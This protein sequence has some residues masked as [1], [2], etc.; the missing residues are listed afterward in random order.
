MDFEDLKV[1]IPQ[2]LSDEMIEYAEN[3]A[4][5]HSRYLFVTRRGKR[6]HCYCTHCNGMFE[7]QGLNVGKQ[8][9]CEK[10]NSLC[11]VKSAA[12][13]RNK[14]VDEVYFVYYAKSVIDPKA[15]VATGIY[16]VRD[17]RFSYRNVKTHFEL[18]AMYLFIPREGS[19]MWRRI[20]YQ[21]MAEGFVYVGEWTPC[22][23]TYS[24]GVLMKKAREF[25]SHESIKQAVQD[26][27]FAWSGWDQYDYR[28]DS[29]MV[30]FFGLYARYPCVEYLVK[31][32]FDN[33]VGGKL[34]GE[35]NYKTINW[36]GKTLFDV[37]R[38]TKKELNEIKRKNITLD[39]ELL[40]ILQMS[41]K[42]RSNFSLEEAMAFCK[43]FNYSIGTL[44]KLN[45]YAHLRRISNYLKNQKHKN[46]FVT[47]S[48]ALTTWR[49][50]LNDCEIMQM[51]LSDESVVFPRN[52]YQAHQ[53]TIKQV[54]IKADEKLN[55]QI[56][57]RLKSLNRYCF[58]F[59]GLMIRPVESTEELIAEGKTLHHCVG[60]YGNRY[61]EGKTDILVIRRI[62]E[63]DKPY[64]TVEITDGH[65]RQ[66]HGAKNCNPTE[67]VQAFMAEFTKQ[68]LKPKEREGKVA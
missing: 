35:R 64:F 67:D 66:V 11:Y 19:Y 16:A 55:Q 65:V 63:P 62:E 57:D 61:A 25:V 12:R 1:H 22:A 43:D 38:I 15:I 23:T 8:A 39:F 59:G 2:S 31:L 6:Q 46:H 24:M 5:L 42:D 49:D 41:L 34:A 52:L 53:N 68:K 36:Q 7:T 3:V 20:A 40:K 21:S 37:L 18:V 4:L 9:H 32:G 45:K 51:D 14:M 13:G 26:T 50:Y 10:C 48:G 56:R 30:A 29:D 28:R 54:K 44:E 47:V 27:P 17:Y 58:E 60:T 33:I